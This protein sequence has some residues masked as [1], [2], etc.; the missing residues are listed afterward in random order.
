MPGRYEAVRKPSSLQKNVAYYVMG[1][2]RWRYTDTLESVTARSI[3]LHLQLDD[4][5]R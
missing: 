3:P 5:S 2:E 1:A 4:E